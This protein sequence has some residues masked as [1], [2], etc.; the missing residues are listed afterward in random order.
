MIGAGMWIQ[1]MLPATLVQLDRLRTQEPEW[2]E[3]PY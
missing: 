2:F 1:L 3:I